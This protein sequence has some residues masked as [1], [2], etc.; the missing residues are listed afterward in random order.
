MPL[1]SVQVPAGVEP[2][3]QFL[4]DHAGQQVMVT[5]PPGVSA[6]QQIQV[7]APDPP[8]AAA[9][10]LN[11]P[12]HWK[13]MI[14][15]KQS[16]AKEEAVKL[17]Y[18]L[19]G[20]K[21]DVWL[22]INNEDKSVA[23]MKEAVHESETFL[24]ILTPS[25]FKSEYCLNEL[26]WAREF[27]KTIV[28]CYPQDENVGEI[29]ST[30]P[31]EVAFIRSVDSKKVDMSDPRFF[32]VSLEMIR[33]ASK[34]AAVGA[35]VGAKVGAAVGAAVGAVTGAATG[36]ANRQIARNQIAPAPQP[37]VMGRPPPPG[38]PP[39]GSYQTVS[40]VGPVTVCCACTF[41]GGVFCL[42]PLDRK[43]VW[44]VGANH[45]DAVTGQYDAKVGPCRC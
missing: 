26:K 2:G 8:V 30:A 38:A 44:K 45:Y 23:A 18:E 24:C 5:V 27:E 16:E 34:G 21:D 1:L 42:C 4:I 6:G 39:N 11:P 37:Q 15:Y 33:G 29:L 22:D 31:E 12:G 20:N 41:Y 25:Y 35:A 43:E 19:T 28:S 9:P 7:Q 17:A 32:A 13:Y 40:Y 14:S 36:A 10:V 3:Q